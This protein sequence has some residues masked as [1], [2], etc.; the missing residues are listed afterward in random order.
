MC[1]LLISCAAARSQH[2]EASHPIMSYKAWVRNQSGFLSLHQ[3]AASPDAD[4]LLAPKLHLQ[5]TEDANTCDGA[6]FD[7]QTMLWNL[8]LRAIACSE[9]L[10]GSTPVR[11]LRKSISAL[12]LLNLCICS[13]F[14][15]PLFE[16]SKKQIPIVERHA[17]LSAIVSS[18][19]L[20]GGQTLL[21]SLLKSSKK[22]SIQQA[23]R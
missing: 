2:A 6:L 8:P 17:A 1:C 12:L 13:V 5:V 15:L 23:F 16:N 19:I 22:P 4:H 9:P 11:I 7:P 18:L 20:L 21:L 10:L 3:P 14:S